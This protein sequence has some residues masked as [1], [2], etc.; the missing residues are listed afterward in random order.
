MGDAD[1]VKMAKRPQQQVNLRFLH[2]A[3]QLQ[4]SSLTLIELQQKKTR[5]CQVR[6]R[7]S[8]KRLSLLPKTIKPLA[9]YINTFERT[10]CSCW[11]DLAV[12]QN[13]HNYWLEYVTQTHLLNRT[14]SITLR[15]QE[16]PHPPPSITSQGGNYILELQLKAQRV[17]FSIQRTADSAKASQQH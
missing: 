4:F 15:A 16:W 17:R 5:T 3:S 10:S 7:R 13:R 12:R 2:A 9:S 11:A 1:C 6:M 8:D 14:L